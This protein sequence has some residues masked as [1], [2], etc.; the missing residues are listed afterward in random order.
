MIT[1]PMD[2]HG[3]R[4]QKIHI[5]LDTDDCAS[6]DSR[7]ADTAG[8]TQ[9]QDDLQLALTDQRHHR[10]QNEQPR[11]GHPGIDKPLHHDIEL[12]AEEPGRRT[13]QQG[14]QQVDTGCGEANDHRNARSEDDS[15][16]D[17]SPQLVGTQ[18]ILP[19]R[20]GVPVQQVNFVHLVGGQHIGEDT[21]E[22]QQHHDD[23]THGA[24][25]LF[26]DK[27]RKNSI[28]RGRLFCSIGRAS[29]VVTSVTGFLF[30]IEL[31]QLRE[32]SKIKY[33]PPL[34]K[35]AVSLHSCQRFDILKTA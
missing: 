11:E 18:W 26:P 35:R 31:C 24:Q 19:G 8:N 7:T 10:D 13:D 33:A 28:R 3:L 29:L 9:D 32:K 23:A 15:T 21:A 14:D 1:S 16:E 30:L 6:R 2:A 4:G 12:A 20:W 17:V 5:F 34:K 27:P 25:R 22:K